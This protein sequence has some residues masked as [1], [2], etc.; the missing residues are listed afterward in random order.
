[1]DNM[2]ILARA[3]AADEHVSGTMFTF[4]RQNWNDC[5]LSHMKIQ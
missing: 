4:E 3:A 5:N 1:M 2:V